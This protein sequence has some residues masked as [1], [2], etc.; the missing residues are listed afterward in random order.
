MREHVDLCLHELLPRLTRKPETVGTVGWNRFA[1]A[2]KGFDDSE[3]SPSFLGTHHAIA[4]ESFLAS[5]GL[6][7]DRTIG[8]GLIG[9]NF[10]ASGAHKTEAPAL[11]EIN[12]TMR[13]RHPRVSHRYIGEFCACVEAGEAPSGSIETIDDVDDL[14]R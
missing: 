13:G 12:A 14:H 1:L 4:R 10:S 8:G 5:N 6:I 2:T 7:N 11:V 3:G 9:R